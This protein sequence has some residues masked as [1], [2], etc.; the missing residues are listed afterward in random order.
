[1]IARKD[2]FAIAAVILVII[3]AFSTLFLAALWIGAVIFIHGL[4]EMHPMSDVDLNA[5][6]EE[7]I[8]LFM[9]ALITIG[10]LA[11]LAATVGAFWATL[12]LDD[13]RR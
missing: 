12:R 5:G 9:G 2:G 11:G 8:E 10:S 4:S 1:M 7:V 6:P 13:L 3:P